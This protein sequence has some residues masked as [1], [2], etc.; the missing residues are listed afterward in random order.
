[1]A[2]LD[3]ML[4]GAQSGGVNGLGPPS[5]AIMAESTTRHSAPTMINVIPT[6]KNSERHMARFPF[7]RDNPIRRNDLLRR[8]RDRAAMYFQSWVV[9]VIGNRGS[10]L[11]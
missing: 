7:L 10:S 1:M 2:P 8:Q 5:L 6:A 9:S 11:A 3:I 4:Q